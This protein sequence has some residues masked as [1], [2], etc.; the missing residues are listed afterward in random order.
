MLLF[1]RTY[2]E[3]LTVLKLLQYVLVN[4]ENNTKEISTN[5]EVN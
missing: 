3:Y 1:F 5:I 2:S 4:F